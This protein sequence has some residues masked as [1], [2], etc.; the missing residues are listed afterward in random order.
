MVFFFIL[1]TCLLMLYQYG[2]EEELK[3]N[4]NRLLRLLFG[5]K[6]SFPI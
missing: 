3:D 1:I 2:K 6:A 5:R 4:L